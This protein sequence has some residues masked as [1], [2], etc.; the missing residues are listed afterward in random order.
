MDFSEF[1][2]E[3]TIKF[4]KN[5]IVINITLFLY[6]EREKFSRWVLSTPVYYFKSKQPRRKRLL[7]SIALN[8]IISKNILI[9]YDMA[10]QNVI[11]SPKI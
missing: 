8:N 6:Y 10:L 4:D 7:V 5:F 3:S 11:L 2:N 9:G 1:K